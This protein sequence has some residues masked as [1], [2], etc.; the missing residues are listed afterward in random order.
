MG[1]GARTRHPVDTA[2]RAVEEVYRLT[3]DV[4]I[5]TL[6]DLGFA[7]D[8]I[9]M[10]ARIAHQDPQTIGNPR[11]VDQAGYEQIYKRAFDAGNR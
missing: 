3:E 11:E 8:E 6:Q 1:K 4:R 2:E 5:P 7:E 10:L 9:P